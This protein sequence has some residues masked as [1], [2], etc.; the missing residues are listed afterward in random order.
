MTTISRGVSINS[1]CTK[2]NDIGRMI[3][4]VKKYKYRF[5][6]YTRYKNKFQVDRRSKGKNTIKV[7]SDS[8]SRMGN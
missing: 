7:K 5:L 3:T 6:P 1:F 4:I 2:K 8:L